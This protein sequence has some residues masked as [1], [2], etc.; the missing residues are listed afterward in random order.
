MKKDVRNLAHLSPREKRQLLA[1]LLQ[2]RARRRS[3]SSRPSLAEEQLGAFDKF[4]VTSAQL[5]DEVVL[6]PTIGADGLPRPPGS[7]PAHIFLTGATGFLGSFLL[8][9]LL[10]TTQAD[11]YCLVRCSTAQAGRLRIQAKLD[12]YLP[13]S[14]YDYSRIIAVP[15]DLSKP[16][17][18]LSQ[19]QFQRLA[20]KIDMLYHSGAMVNWIDSFEKLKPTNVLGTQEILRLSSHSRLKPLHYVSSLA[21][22]PLVRN[23]QASV[24]R[25]ED[26]LDHGG[27]LY[28]GY[29]QSK[30]VAEKV[31]AVAR[32]RGLPVTVY[33]PGMITGHSETGAW[34]TS[35]FTCQLLKSWI[36]TGYV[37]DLEAAMDMTPVDYVSRAI[38][39]LSLQRHS[40]GRIFHLANPQAVDVQQLYDWLR[41]LGYRLEPLPYEQWRAALIQ[42]AELAPQKRLR[43]LVPLLVARESEGASQWVSGVP[44][45]DCTDTMN[46][47]AETSISCPSIDERTIGV[48][49][50]FLVQS[51]FLPHVSLPL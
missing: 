31:V 7:E 36:T 41:A 43:A 22:F 34:N 30:W 26:P 19:E 8:Y 37:P 14:K 18:G 29:T 25:E 27:L 42:L 15:G 50:S 49:F 28:G 46:E 2:K 10:E 38:T 40:A 5:Q 20:N 13:G 33:R 3:N 35:D 17:L 24:V 48:Y 39:Y 51:G 11:I 32:S 21:V 47:L 44:Q 1:E 16:R 45:F 23:A 6:D 12:S 4:A 9:E